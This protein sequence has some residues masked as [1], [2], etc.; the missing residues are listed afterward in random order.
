[1]RVEKERERKRDKVEN[2][3][4]VGRPV[5]WK[6]EVEEE[7]RGQGVPVRVEGRLGGWWL[8]LRPRPLG[9]CENLYSLGAEGATA[10]QRGGACGGGGCSLSYTK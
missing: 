6:N 4:L 7:S 1:M 9:T 2:P 8:S 10:G 5:G 3:L